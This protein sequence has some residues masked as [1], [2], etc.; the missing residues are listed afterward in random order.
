MAAIDFQLLANAGF[1]PAKYQAGEI[2][3]SEGDEGDNMYVIRSGQVE[4]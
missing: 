3:F 4:V 2:I 1:P